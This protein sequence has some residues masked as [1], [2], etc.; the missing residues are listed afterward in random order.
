MSNQSEST[1]LPA[2]AGEMGLLTDLY[3]LTMAQS[4]FAEGMDGQATF[5]LYIREYPPDRGYLV[6]AGIGDALDCLAALTFNADSVAYLRDTGIFTDDFLE[7]LGN[8][9]FTRLRPSDA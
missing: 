3:E 7:Y 2:P 9:R 5:S 4:Y 1:Y 8:F 6:A